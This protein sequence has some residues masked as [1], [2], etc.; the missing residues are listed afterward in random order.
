MKERF[1]TTWFQVAHKADNRQV[2]SGLLRR[3]ETVPEYR[4][5]EANI[6]QF[7]ECLADAYNE[8]DREGYDVVNVVPLNM[9]VSDEVFGKRGRQSEFMGEVG[10]S[11]TK[12]AVVVGKQRD[13]KDS[14]VLG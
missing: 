8:L 9:A 14:E 10:F 13:I 12:G 6:N 5:T 7:A 11:I 2:R 1:A 4:P 3:K